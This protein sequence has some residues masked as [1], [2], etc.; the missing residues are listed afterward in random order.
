MV[1]ICVPGRKD[2]AA[3]NLHDAPILLCHAGDSSTSSRPKWRPIGQ[4]AVL[5]GEGACG[6]HARVTL[7]MTGTPA[8]ERT[9]LGLSLG[10]WSEWVAAILTG[11]SL[12]LG[13][14]ILLQDRRKEDRRHANAISYWMNTAPQGETQVLEVGV[15]NGSDAPISSIRLGVVFSRFTD[16]WSDLSFG[17]AVRFL[18][19]RNRADLWKVDSALSNSRLQSGAHG[20]L[21]MPNESE[22]LSTPSEIKYIASDYEYVLIFTDGRNKRWKRTI[23]TGELKRIR[24]RLDR[25]YGIPLQL[26]APFLILGL[27]I[28]TF[29]ANVFRRKSKPA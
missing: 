5:C 21:L 1:P 24:G 19:Q 10:P 2:L 16:I 8:G 11:G 14:Y 3:L 20:H 6:Y 4:Y 18:R 25:R 9:W 29:F 15:H 17:N 28:A 7:W 23:R 22:F 13:F 27:V 12:L 26:M